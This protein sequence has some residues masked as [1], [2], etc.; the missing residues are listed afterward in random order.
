MAT[1]MRG[2][3][4]RLESRSRSTSIVVSHVGSPYLTFANSARDLNSAD[5]GTQYM[6][7]NGNSM[8]LLS[9]QIAEITVRTTIGAIPLG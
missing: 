3:L 9:V 6:N 8:R 5:L 4:C 1:Q 2:C 7:Q